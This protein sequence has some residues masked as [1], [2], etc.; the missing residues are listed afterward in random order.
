MASLLILPGLIKE[1][2]IREKFIVLC[3]LNVNFET[4]K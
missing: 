4:G 2:T 1:D 3:T